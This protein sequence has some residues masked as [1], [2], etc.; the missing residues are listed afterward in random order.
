MFMFIVSTYSIIPKV[1]SHLIDNYHWPLRSHFILPVINDWFA[2]ICVWQA[3]AYLRLVEAT[4][5]MDLLTKIP[6]WLIKTVLS[7]GLW[8]KTLLWLVEA[9]LT[10]EPLSH[11]AGT[12]PRSTPGWI[13]LTCLVPACLF[14]DKPDISNPEHDVYKAKNLEVEK[15]TGVNGLCY[16]AVFQWFVSRLDTYR[17]CIKTWPER[18]LGSCAFVL[19]SSAGWDEQKHLCWV[20]GHLDIRNCFG[21]VTTADQPHER[22][23]DCN[24]KILQDKIQETWRNEVTSGIKVVNW[25]C[26]MSHQHNSCWDIRGVFVKGLNSLTTSGPLLFLRY[27]FW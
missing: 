16:P 23:D 7:G 18:L 19:W 27:L 20:C 22:E 4:L 24:K 1:K 12:F 26:F 25:M 10:V 21:P 6:L 15:E 2:E 5:S 3:Q 17:R 14:E 13:S 8:T 9:A 11:S